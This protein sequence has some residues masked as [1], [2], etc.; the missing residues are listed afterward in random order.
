MVSPII[1]RKNIGKL[2]KIIFKR[3]RRSQTSLIRAP[4]D[5]PLRLPYTPEVAFCSDKLERIYVSMHST[6]TGIVRHLNPSLRSSMPP[7][8]S[9]LSLHSSIKLRERD[10]NIELVKKYPVYYVTVL[11][12]LNFL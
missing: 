4:C 12:F 8:N 9:P 6:T 1:R 3:E 2:S 7:F 11:S 10:L 5:Y